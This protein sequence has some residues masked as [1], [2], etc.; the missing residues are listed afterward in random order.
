VDD[1]VAGQHAPRL[2]PFVGKRDLIAVAHATRDTNVQRLL[3]TQQPMAMTHVAFFVR[4]L[5]AALAD[6]APAVIDI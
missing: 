1:D 4:D 5:A 2:A 3:V 6:V